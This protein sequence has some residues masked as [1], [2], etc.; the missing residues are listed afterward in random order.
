MYPEDRV[1]VAY[2]PKPADFSVVQTEGWY[3]IPQKHAPKGLH[4]EYFSFYFGSKFTAEKWAIHYYAPRLGHE[5]MTRHAL[6]PNQ[7]NHPRAQEMYYKVQLGPLQKLKRPIISLR[8]RR[9]TFLHTTWDRFQ[10]AT[11]IN[12]LFVDGDQYV[13]RV[14]ATLKERGIQAER[15]YRVRE[16]G[17]VYDVPLAI[18]CKNGR[19]DLTATEMA[20]NKEMLDQF[21]ANIAAQVAAQGGQQ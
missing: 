2:M 11:E 17:V 1:L 20:Q 18:F 12:D 7:P 4:A 15:N 8:W 13:D 21:A 5:L 14:Y 3:R 19:I 6:F 9:V 10:D 16:P